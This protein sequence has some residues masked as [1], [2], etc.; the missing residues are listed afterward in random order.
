MIA[1]AWCALVA[2]VGLTV[3]VVVRHARDMHRDRTRVAHVRDSVDFISRELA[4]GS[5][6]LAALARAADVAGDAQVGTALRTRSAA[7]RMGA[8]VVGD[9]GSER[10]SVPELGHLFRLWSIS[11]THGVGLSGLT[12]SYVVDLDA[13][14]AHISRSQSAMAGARLTVV[15]LL[16]LPCGAVALG[17]T[18]GFG[19]LRFLT[20]NGLGLMLS[21]AGVVLICAG[22]LWAE[23]LTITVLGG[24]G[25]RAGPGHGPL[26]AARNLDVVA[27]ALTSGMPLVLAWATGVG[28]NKE[29]A[30]LR[31]GADS[32][33][34]DAVS[35]DPFYG[36][37]A[38]Q[39]AHH[40]RSG[41]ALAEGMRDQA[42]RLRRLA[43]D[44]STAGAERVLIALAAPLTLCFLPAFVLVGLVPLAIGLAGL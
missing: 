11:H 5:L 14:L 25:G 13:Q 20:A 7:V 40:A 30:L 38:R 1:A 4:A 21:T 39:A 10:T 41:A 2:I 9:A 24:V 37:V 44:Q 43:A 12:R 19:T 32:A 42:E 3:S 18:M 17:Q 23:K 27:A 33:A 22:A 6:P 16:A 31:L 35:S 26:T 34:W 15:V 29:T 28:D 36:P 8:D